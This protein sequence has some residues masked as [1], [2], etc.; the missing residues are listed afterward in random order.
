MGEHPVIYMCA[1]SQTTPLRTIMDQ[2]VVTMEAACRL[3]S[4]EGT[5]VFVID[6]HGLRSHLN[7]DFA[8]LK[9]LAD[10][11]GTVYAER[12]FKIIIVDFSSAANAA[13]WM[14]KPMLRPATREKFYFVG[15]RKAKELIREMFDTAT[16]Q[17]I[18]TSLDV[19]RDPNKT[20]EDRALHARRTNLCASAHTEEPTAAKPLR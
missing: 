12:I 11:L 6:M 18:C 20:A 3:T 8:A 14:L 1:R 15:E 16:C 9:D 19:N 13:W 5:L 17:C 10:I 7:M 2:I 4:D